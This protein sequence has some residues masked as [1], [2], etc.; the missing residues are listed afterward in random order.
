MLQHFRN[1]LVGWFSKI[2]IGLISLAFALFGIQYYLVS[3]RSNPSVVTVNGE[4]IG[5]SDLTAA[6]NRQ[7]N[8]LLNQYGTSLRLTTELQEQL[9]EKAL[10]DLILRTVMY[11]GVHKAGFVVSP[12]VVQAVI[13]QMPAFQ[14]DG[15][16]SPDRFQHLIYNLSYSENSFYQDLMRSLLV[17]QFSEGIIQTAFALPN[18]IDQ[19]YEVAEQ[20]RDFKYVTLPVKDFE[21]EVTVKDADIKSYYDA[22]KKEY[23][24]EAQ[25]SVDY[26][27]L[28]IESLKTKQT[29]SDAEVQDYYQNNQMAFASPMRWQVAKGVVPIATDAKVT[30]IEAAKNRV[31]LLSKQLGQEQ[32]LPADVKMQWVS[33]AK[34]NTDLVKLFTTMKVGQVSPVQ[35]K[36]EGFVVYKLLVVEEA[37]PQPLSAVR[38]QVN[39]A[40]LKQKAEHEYTSLSDQIAELAFTHPD[41][42]AS[43]AQAVG[44]PVKSTGMFTHRGNKDGLEA[45]PKIVSAAFSD[46]VLQQGSNSSPI[47]LGNGRLVV[48][49]V[50]TSQPAQVLPIENVKDKIVALLKR[51]QAQIAMEKIAN[52]IVEK[53]R[54]GNNAEDLLRAHNLVWRQQSG[55]SRQ[56][57]GVNH[58]ILQLAFH[59][60]APN[61]K[62]AAYGSTALSEG[63]Y[64]IVSVEKVIPAQ[65]KTMTSEQRESFKNSLAVNYGSADFNIYVKDLRHKAKVNKLQKQSESSTASAPDVSDDY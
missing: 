53:L 60:P 48:L 2:L 43:V 5:T 11:Q 46:E 56:E 3:S 64:A 40:I 22:H 28:N 7:R 4:K 41:S 19:A 10:N 20:K 49:R 32:K 13:E 35:Q 47:D 52:T 23:Q 34:D 21:S 44:V 25:V 27:E 57:K 24:S 58:E 65:V 8:Q 1:H 26:V 45:S 18:E 55:A 50:K 38:S 63:D 61:Q 17:S 9:R 12:L 29:V 54:S 14:V 15:K 42:L 6:Y 51:Q 33:P 36:Q 31:E 59:Q 37:K 30:D 39:E 62:A 16:F